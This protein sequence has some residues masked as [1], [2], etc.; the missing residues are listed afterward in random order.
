MKAGV[1]A[2]VGVGVGKCVEPSVAA[3]LVDLAE[4]VV[5][6]VEGAGGDAGAKMREGRGEGFA[7]DDIVRRAGDVGGDLGGRRG[8]LWREGGEGGIGGVGGDEADGTVERAPCF[9][10]VATGGEDGDSSGGGLEGVVV[11]R[12]G[13][14][15]S[16][17]VG[18]VRESRAG[19]VESGSGDA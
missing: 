9:A 18:V 17:G 19:G 10:I 4:A 7:R 6:G 2:V 14:D 11:G 13:G 5:C 1:E 3:K 15:V 16:G 12:G 8:D